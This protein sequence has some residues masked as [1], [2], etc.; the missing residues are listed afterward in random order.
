MK[1][2]FK[3]MCDYNRDFAKKMFLRGSKIVLFFGMINF[4]YISTIVVSRDYGILTQ[5]EKN[6]FNDVIYCKKCYNKIIMNEDN[7]I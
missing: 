1:Q 5:K 4:I 7:K 2:F 3:E 6:Y